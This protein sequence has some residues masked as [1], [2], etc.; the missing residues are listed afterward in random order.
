MGCRWQGSSRSWCPLELAFWTRV[1]LSRGDGEPSPGECGL[2][3]QGKGRC[4]RKGLGGLILGLLEADHA[5]VSPF[6]SHTFFGLFHSLRSLRNVSCAGPGE[7]KYKSSAALQELT[8]RKLAS[9]RRCTESWMKW[10]GERGKV[11]LSL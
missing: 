7:Q 4:Q 10:G 11:R 1:S 5:H 2:G 9:E 6:L 3:E 8:S